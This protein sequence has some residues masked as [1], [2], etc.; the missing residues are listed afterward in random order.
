MPV[1]EPYPRIFRMGQP[2]DAAAEAQKPSALP[3]REQMNTVPEE[4]TRAA[5]V[6]WKCSQLMKTQHQDRSY[7]LFGSKNTYCSGVTERAS[8]QS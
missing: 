1:W 5:P 7:Y 3:T 2:N 8:V 4:R 6:W